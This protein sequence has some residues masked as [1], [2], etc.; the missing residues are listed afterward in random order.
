MNDPFYN[1]GLTTICPISA[2]ALVVL[3]A[4]DS[5]VRRDSWSVYHNLHMCRLG[6][7]HHATTSTSQFPQSRVHTR[8][9]SKPK[10][11]NA[12][13]R[14]HTSHYPIIL[15]RRGENPTADRARRPQRGS[16]T[17]CTPTT[18][19]DQRHTPKN[20]QTYPTP[21]PPFSGGQGPTS[22]TAPSSHRGGGAGRGGRPQLHLR[23]QQPHHHKKNL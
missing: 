5:D 1:N 22:P 4:G 23:H 14:P 18:I 21:P 17:D 8:R 3:Q 20:T 2:R 15:S 19:A 6:V 13:L 7:C 12:N 16:K 9:S 10:K 11:L